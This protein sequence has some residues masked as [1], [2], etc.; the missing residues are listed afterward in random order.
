MRILQVSYISNKVL[1]IC[2]LKKCLHGSRL[3][4][5]HLTW[6]SHSSCIASIFRSKIKGTLTF[7]VFR[8]PLLLREVWY[9][10]IGDT[11]HNCTLSY[12][13]DSRLFMI[14][15]L[16]QSVPRHNRLCRIFV[17]ALYKWKLHLALKLMV[18]SHIH[19]CVGKK[20]NVCR[21]ILSTM[22]WITLFCKLSNLLEV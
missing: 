3:C 16:F 9:L 15:N 5:P 10:D 22:V 13:K 19:G 7:P 11:S 1:G 18:K 20:W 4:L 17:V 21:P 6:W 2:L 14:C 8:C 12:M